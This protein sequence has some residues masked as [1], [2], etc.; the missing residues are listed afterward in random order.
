MGKVNLLTSSFEGQLGE[1]Y[2]AKWKGLHTI[3]AIPFSHA[4]HGERSTNAVRA[5]EKLNRICGGIAKIFFQYL[6]LTAKDMLKHN[7]VARWLRV[8]LVDNQFVIGNFVTA[9]VDR[10]NAA[11]NSCTVNFSTGAFTVDISF[12]D[13]AD[14]S[15]NTQGAFLFVDDNGKVIYKSGFSGDHFVYAGVARLDPAQSYYAM[16]LRSDYNGK[17]WEPNTFRVLAATVI[18]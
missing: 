7:A 11:I 15:E 8:L 10:E 6:A 14:P 12:T 18:S 5:F 13:I 1:T 3:K 17:K 4:P 16:L 9:V 2:G